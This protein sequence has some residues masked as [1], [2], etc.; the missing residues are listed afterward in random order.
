MQNSTTSKNN[1]C[2][3]YVI[4]KALFAHL[5]VLLLLIMTGDDGCNDCCIHVMFD[6]EFDKTEVE[7]SGMLYLQY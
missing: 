4:C 6:G 1:E 5:M 2:Q 7:D 3:A